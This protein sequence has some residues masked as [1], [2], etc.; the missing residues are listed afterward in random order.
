M[1]D[2]LSEGWVEHECRIEKVKRKYSH[3]NRLL[4]AFVLCKFVL[5]N[6][7]TVALRLFHTAF[8]A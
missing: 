4:L 8:S 5:Y 7:H 2:L 3:W 1:F 6:A